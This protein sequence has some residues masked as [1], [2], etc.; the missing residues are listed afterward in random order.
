[1]KQGV[2]AVTFTLDAIPDQVGVEPFLLL[3][4]RVPADNLKR[5]ELNS[6]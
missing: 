3:I 2:N 1:M 5:C 4:D 6:E